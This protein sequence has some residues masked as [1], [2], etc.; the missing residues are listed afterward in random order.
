[1]PVTF[2]APALNSDG[3]PAG[4]VPFTTGVT[5]TS[6]GTSGWGEPVSYTV[7][8]GDGSSPAPA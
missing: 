5:V 8:F 7:D 6:G 1:M 4:A 2:T 3:Y